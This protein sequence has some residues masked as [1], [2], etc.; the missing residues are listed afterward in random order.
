[1]CTSSVHVWGGGVRELGM[2]ERNGVLGLVH[3]IV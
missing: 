1:M 3:V 2:Y